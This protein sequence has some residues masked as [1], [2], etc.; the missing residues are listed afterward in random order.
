MILPVVHAVPPFAKGGQGGFLWAAEYQMPL[1]PPQFPFFKGGSE[2]V[3]RPRV[4]G[5]DQ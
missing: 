3:R 4:M 5:A 2:D 1:N